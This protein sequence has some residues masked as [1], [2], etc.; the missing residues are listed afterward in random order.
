[1][2]PKQ[3][4]SKGFV[5]QFSNFEMKNDDNEKKKMMCGKR[6]RKMTDQE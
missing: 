4:G 1:V 2:V 3:F 6:E 5:E